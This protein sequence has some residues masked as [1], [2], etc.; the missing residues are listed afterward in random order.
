MKETVNRIKELWRDFQRKLWSSKAWMRFYFMLETVDSRY[1]E[2]IRDPVWRFF[3]ERKLAYWELQRRAIK[4]WE[5]RGVIEVVR[6]DEDG[7]P[8]RY[9]EHNYM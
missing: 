8:M 9:E 2:F 6:K 4:F 1:R 5:E 7:R 3:Y